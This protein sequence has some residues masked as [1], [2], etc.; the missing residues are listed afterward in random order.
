MVIDGEEGGL[1][2]K[3]GWEVRER[4]WNRS[5]RREICSIRRGVSRIGWKGGLAKRGR[6]MIHLP[7]RSLM[8]F[9]GGAAMM[10]G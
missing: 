7:L 4:G 8:V 2:N 3:R 9:S 6:T 10:G 1:G 5:R